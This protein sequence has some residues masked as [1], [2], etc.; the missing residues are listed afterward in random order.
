LLYYCV[1]NHCNPLNFRKEKIL[2]RW[3][4]LEESGRNELAAAPA[5]YRAEGHPW[6]VPPQ[7]EWRPLD[8]C[9]EP[10][11]DTDL[12]QVRLTRASV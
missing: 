8:A 4:K 10:V 11:T 9:A 3:K 7:T 12:I 6:V 5:P 1:R 2:R